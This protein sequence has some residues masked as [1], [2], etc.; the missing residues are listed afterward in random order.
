MLKWELKK[1][2]KEKVIFAILVILILNISVITF[3]KLDYNDEKEKKEYDTNRDSLKEI[4]SLKKDKERDRSLNVLAEAAGD[5]LEKDRTDLYE[6]IDFYRVFHFRIG[7]LLVNASMVI[8][9][10]I[11]FS[12]IYIYERNSKVDR[13]IFSSKNKFRVLYSKLGLT[14][15]IPTGIYAFYILVIGVITV[16]QYGPPKGGKLQAYRMVEM[17]LLLKGS[18]TIQQYV[19]ATGM[20]LV[21]M[22]I[23]LAVY[24]SV[25]SA[26][27][28]SL[29]G[30]IAGSS[31]ILFL[32]KVMTGLK[33][34]PEEFMNVLKNINFVDIFANPQILVG[35]EKGCL[36]VLNSHLDLHY[37]CYMVLFALLVLGILIHVYLFQK[38]I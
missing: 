5:K 15:L 38:R 34:L 28:R 36:T 2:R 29:T 30:S 21:G 14:F 6:N 24:A 25:C 13:M 35:M 11:I 19:F 22:Y 31:M 4:S 23:L 16:L 10:I 12:Q 27:S 33:F 20:T 37:I 1:I 32:F 8:I 3:L 9:I 26:L 17:P 18:P 7:N